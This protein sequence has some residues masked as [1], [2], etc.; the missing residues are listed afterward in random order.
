MDGPP[1][2]NVGSADN[3]VREGWLNR[4]KAAEGTVPEALAPRGPRHANKGAWSGEVWDQNPVGV[5]ATISV[6]M[7]IGM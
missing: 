6:L 1:A 3:P 4:Q 5:L 2:G 7:P